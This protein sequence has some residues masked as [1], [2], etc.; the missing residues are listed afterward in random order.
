[1]GKR[2]SRRL[3]EGIADYAAADVIQMHEVRGIDLLADHLQ[4]RYPDCDVV[5][6]NVFRGKSAYH[7]VVFLPPWPAA[8]DD[9][10]V[11]FTDTQGRP[12]ALG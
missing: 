10:Y 1:M 11:L 4:A 6:A 7:L 9:A 3:L 12:V 5:Y 8:G 2:L